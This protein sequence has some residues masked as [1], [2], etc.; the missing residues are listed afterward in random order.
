MTV[1]ASRGDIRYYPLQR[2]WT[3]KIRPHLTDE[4]LNATLVKDFNKFTWGRWRQKFKRGELPFT[5]ESCDWWCTHR[6]PMPRYW[7]YVKHAACHWTANWALELAQLVEPNRQ[8]RIITSQKHGVGRWQLSLRLQFPSNGD[9]TQR[10][11]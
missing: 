9:L 7:Q 4:K 3:K 8:W 5:Y 1:M 11:F 6:G 10:M 2:H